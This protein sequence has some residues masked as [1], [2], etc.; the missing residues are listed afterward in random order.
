MGMSAGSR[1]PPTREGDDEPTSR[2]PVPRAPVIP[3]EAPEKPTL[4]TTGRVST[5]RGV[6]PNLAKTI[7]D[8][9]DDEEYPEDATTIDPELPSGMP[10]SRRFDPGGNDDN[11]LTKPR[12][13]TNLV[14]IEDEDVRPPLATVIGK[15]NPHA[16]KL[17]PA[18]PVHDLG[19]TNP[20]DTPPPP[21]EDTVTNRVRGPVLPLA[22][23]PRSEPF[24]AV[25]MKTPADPEE[26]Q[27]KA[28]EKA[29]RVLPEVR[30]RAMSE[31]NA[32]QTPPRGM[33]FLAPPHDP[34]EARSRRLRDNVIWGSVAV[35][36]AAVVMLA[37]WFLAR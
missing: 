19:R 10:R 3:D 34:Q 5:R 6:D 20:W 24:K 17:K 7:R 9:T 36:V 33:G 16:G 29:A 15:R 30:I 26:E 8:D 1:K 37:V 23:G 18:P 11:L 31:L 22:P 35:M 21:P 4:P 14:I 12:A 32:N 25:S 13:A 28:N 2:Q 27:A